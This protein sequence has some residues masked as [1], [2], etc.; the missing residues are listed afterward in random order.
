MTIVQH[1][2]Q[3][4]V[5]QRDWIRNQMIICNQQVQK[6]KQIIKLHHNNSTHVWARRHMLNKVILCIYQFYGDR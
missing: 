2:E 6:F 3:K 1:V 5:E 4:V